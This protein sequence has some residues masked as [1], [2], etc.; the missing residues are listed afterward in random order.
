LE[1]TKEMNAKDRARVLQYQTSFPSF[2]INQGF[3]LRK[4]LWKVIKEYAAS[5]NGKILD[6]GCG[7][8]PYE[9]AF[10]VCESYT[11]LDVT[12]SGHSHENSRIDILYDGRK[13]PFSNRTFDKV[14]CFEVFEHLEDPAASLE[15]IARVLK[16]GGE[17][18]ITIPFMYGEHEIP[19]D[20]QRW[21]SF[22]LARLVEKHHFKIVKLEK[23]N[24]NFGVIAQMFFDEFFPR[25]KVSKINYISVLRIP[26]ITLANFI[27]IMLSMLRIRNQNL[28]SNLVC[29]AVL[30]NVDSNL[31]PLSL[32]RDI[33]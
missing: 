9:T 19:F 3:F 26:L 4:A 27:V 2:F 24:T 8:K 15:E 31:K 30:E 18:F 20:F 6:F 29:I 1:Y 10:S 11:G 17:L 33:I 22:G 21:T 12:Q 7:S 14:V 23:L 5:A 25:R 28:Y 13:L 16:I 32:D